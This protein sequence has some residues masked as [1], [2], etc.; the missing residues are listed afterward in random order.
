[1]ISFFFSN[2]DE[3]RQE[4]DSVVQALIDNFLE[5]RK[6]KLIPKGE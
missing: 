3:I 6:N 4:L 1:M 2:R 5:P